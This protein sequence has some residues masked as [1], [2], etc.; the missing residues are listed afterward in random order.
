MRRLQVILNTAGIGRFSIVVGILLTLGLRRGAI[1]DRTD[2]LLYAASW[3]T[4]LH[5]SVG[6]YL[7]IYLRADSM[8]HRVLEVGGFLGVAALVATFRAP[9][10]WCTALALIM[11]VA[12]I[13]YAL[14]YRTESRAVVKRYARMKMVIE[15]PSILFMSLFAVL[16]RYAP[17]NGRME[18]ILAGT[19][20]LSTT[21]FACGMIAGR[22]YSR[23]LDDLSAP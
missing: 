4:L 10:T 21:L 12:V 13:R 17:V 9:V 7:F 5:L 11:L 18:E 19:I 23:L 15:S 8:I 2:L 14:I 22:V 20:L 6:A 16:F 3:V 1:I